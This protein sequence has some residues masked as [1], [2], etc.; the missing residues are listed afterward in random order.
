MKNLT[1]ERRRE[2]KG[3]G[4]GKRERKREGGREKEESRR[5]QLELAD[6]CCAI[7]HTSQLHV[8]SPRSLIH[9]SH[10]IF[11]NLLHLRDPCS[12]R[13]ETVRRRQSR[14][15]TQRTVGAATVSSRSTVSAQSAASAVKAPFSRVATSASF[16]RL[17][18]SM[19][20]VAAPRRLNRHA[21]NLLYLWHLLSPRCLSL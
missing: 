19:A 1:R 5:R 18:S 21:R 13:S 7:S 15:G 12:Q 2:R 17:N 20:Q 16:D 14:V 6:L 9:D 11:V 8:L 3:I 4:I 10:G